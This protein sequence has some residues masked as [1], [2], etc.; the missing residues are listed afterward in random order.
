M[1]ETKIVKEE[2]KENDESKEKERENTQTKSFLSLQIAT[3]FSF[4]NS[5]ILKINEL[6]NK[7]L[8]ILLI[9][10]LLIYDS[11]NFKKLEEIKLPFSNDY[12]NEGVF[13]FTETKNSG[14]VL[15]SSDKILI[16][17]ISENSYQLNQTINGSEGNEE[18][19]DKN[20][21]N[22]FRSKSKKF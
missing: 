5:K 8:G 12:Y 15:W 22:I 16:Y 2:K 7:R 3:K 17:Q 9:D 14:L 13:D 21:K 4:E 11:K 20:A 19:A 1:E 18:K 10:S 6:S